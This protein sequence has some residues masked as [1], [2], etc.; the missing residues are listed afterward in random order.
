MEGRFGQR[1]YCRSISLTGVDYIAVVIM[2]GTQLGSRTD[3]SG[4]FSK[5]GILVS[6]TKPVVDKPMVYIVTIPLGA[7]CERPGPPA[8]PDPGEIPYPPGIMPWGDSV[9]VRRDCYTNGDQAE[10]TLNGKSLGRRSSGSGLRPDLPWN[11]VYEPGT[12][13]GEE[14]QQGPSGRL[15]CPRHSR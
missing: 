8:I 1:L 10:L 13:V 4:R 12:P 6:D 7:G 14:L 2:A 9:R 3:R 11:I 5:T 15:L